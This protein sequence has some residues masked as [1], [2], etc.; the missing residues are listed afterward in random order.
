MMEAGFDMIDTSGDGALTQDEI[1]AVF[2]NGGPPAGARLKLR[3]KHKAKLHHKAKAHHKVHH[4]VMLKMKH[5][6]KAHHKAHHKINARALLKMKLKFKQPE[7]FED[8]ECPD[9]TA[10]EEEE[11]Y[12]AVVALDDTDE[13]TGE[14]YEQA[15]EEYGIELTEEE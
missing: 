5:K 3:M 14:M 10:E 11:I 15:M 1:D 6:A 13:I 4:K 2:G 8:L 12:A 9:L 7:G